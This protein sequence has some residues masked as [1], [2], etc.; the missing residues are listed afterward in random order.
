MHQL[1]NLWTLATDFFVFETSS[2]GEFKVV[3]EWVQGIYR[4]Q[5]LTLRPF[6]EQIQNTAL[7]PML[8]L[9]RFSGSSKIFQMAE[10]APSGT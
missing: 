2:L 6:L 3:I 7:I 1:L 8:K 4:L 5:N 10:Y 9:S